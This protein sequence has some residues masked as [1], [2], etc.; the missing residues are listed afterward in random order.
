M[1][2]ITGSSRPDFLLFRQFWHVF[3]LKR[4]NTRTLLKYLGRFC[5]IKFHDMVNPSQSPGVWYDGIAIVRVVLGVMLIFQ[6]WQLFRAHDMN[7]IADLLFNM[8][9]PY[10]EAMAYTVK[11][12][13]LLG[14]LFLVIGL[15]TRVMT[16]L[17]VLAYVFITF[18]MGEG[19][20][21]TDNQLPFLFAMISLIFF[22]A[23]AGRFSIDFILF[24]NRKEDK[25]DSDAAIGKKFG[26][27]VSKG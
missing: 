19:K 27:Y 23:G 20:V 10:P 8:S 15:F 22:F 7:V 24:I 12:I 21:L 9:L 11:I 26:R 5:W 1:P 3:P 18:V 6:G 16:A 13:E 4:D 17:L 2:V 25:K 14:G